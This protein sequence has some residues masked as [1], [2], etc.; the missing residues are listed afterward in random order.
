MP[1]CSLQLLVGVWA[2][3]ALMPK[4]Y[5]IT[6]TCCNFLIRLGTELLLCLGAAKTTPS[7]PSELPNISIMRDKRLVGFRA[8]VKK[9]WLQQINEKLYVYMLLNNNITI[10]LSVTTATKKVIWTILSMRLQ[11]QLTYGIN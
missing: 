7:V 9:F 10:N 8:S 4:T 6:W 1:V 3:L 5:N 2:V 11:W